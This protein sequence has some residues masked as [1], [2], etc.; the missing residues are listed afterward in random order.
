MCA[1]LVKL[2]KFPLT[3]KHT[4]AI[5]SNKGASDDVE[6][7]KTQSHF[8][9]IPLVL[10]SKASLPLRLK[11]PPMKWDNPLRPSYVISM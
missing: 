8:Q 1:L 7:L 6:A 5:L 10:F 2:F 4:L 9:G 11:T 3:G